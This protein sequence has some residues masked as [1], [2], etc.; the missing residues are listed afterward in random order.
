MNKGNFEIGHYVM[1]GVQSLGVEQKL[2]FVGRSFKRQLTKKME[3]K[4]YGPIL[5]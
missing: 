5:K 2:L 3:V 4:K 1:V